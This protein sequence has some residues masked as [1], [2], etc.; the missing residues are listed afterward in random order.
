MSMR[1]FVVAVP[2]ALLWG[3]GWQ[4]EAHAQAGQ[5][6]PAGVTTSMVKEG[7]TIFTGQG[8]CFVCHGPDAK[9]RIGPNLTDQTWLHSQGS[10]EQIVQQIKTGVPPTQSV[11]GVVMPPKGG[12]D[13][14]ETQVKAVAAYVWT[15][16]H[17]SAT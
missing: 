8:T 10:Y 17:P 11:S 3:G 9:G 14:S 13:I 16:S 5:P 1:P 6:L 2:A 15:L 4:S 12:S 7:A